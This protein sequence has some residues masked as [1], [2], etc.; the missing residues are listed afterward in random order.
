MSP[1][2]YYFKVRFPDESRGFS[3]SDKFSEEFKHVASYNGIMPTSIKVLRVS[4]NIIETPDFKQYCRVVM[5]CEEGYESRQ[6]DYKQAFALA[7]KHFGWYRVLKPQGD[8]G[9]DVRDTI[10]DQL[11]TPEGKSL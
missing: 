5:V 10:D 6:N 4:K 11:Y 1:T 7:I 2:G 8:R 9:C 3:I